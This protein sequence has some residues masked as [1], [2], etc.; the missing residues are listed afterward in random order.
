MKVLTDKQRQLNYH[1]LVVYFML[2]PSEFK[3]YGKHIKNLNNYKGFTR[4]IFSFRAVVRGDKY[5]QGLTNELTATISK[6]NVILRLLDDEQGYFRY[7]L[8][9]ITFNQNPDLFETNLQ[10]FVIDACKNN[11]NSLKI[12]S[13]YYVDQDEESVEN[14]SII[15][16]IAKG[17]KDAIE[18]KGFKRGIWR[19]L[20][21][22]ETKTVS[23]LELSNALPS[24]LP[25]SNFNEQ[26]P[27]DIYSIE[28]RIKS[29]SD[30]HQRLLIKRLM[31]YWDIPDTEESDNYAAGTVDDL[32]SKALRADCSSRNKPNTKPKELTIA[33]TRVVESRTKRGWGVEIT[34]DGKKIPIYFSS[35][36]ATLIYISTLLKCKTGESLYRSIFKKPLPH[37][38]A[39]RAPEVNWLKRVYKTILSGAPTDFDTWYNKLRDIKSKEPQ[40]IINQG[41]SVANRKIRGALENYPNAIYYCNIENGG[42]QGK[43]VHYYV[44]IPAEDIIVHKDLEHCLYS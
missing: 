1:P 25:S 12:Q 2:Q 11:I 21:S 22:P 24:F 28:K 15:S 38:E 44:N 42:E 29:L 13:Q 4:G 37:N 23:S 32:R 19:K 40:H 7:A 27:D 17:F 30:S 34:V 9:N 35:T 10:K 31:A 33:I 41:K 39:D 8:D 18:L 26:L 16:D 20:I 36:P 6:F 14:A 3:K 5:S 43:N